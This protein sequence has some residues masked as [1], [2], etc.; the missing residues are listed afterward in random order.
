LLARIDAVPAGSRP[1]YLDA[2]ARRFRARLDG[3]AGGYL[4]AAEGFRTLG[5]PFWLAVTLLE[6]AELTADR[7]SLDEARSI[8]EELKAAPWLARAAAAAGAATAQPV[9]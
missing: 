4:A 7:A 3:D 9:A 5:L 1:P 2:Q 6:H 8:F